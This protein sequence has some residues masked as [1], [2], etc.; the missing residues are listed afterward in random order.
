MLHEDK[1]QK[2]PFLIDMLLQLESNKIR[3][4]F[5][6]ASSTTSKTE[7]DDY[8]ILLEADMGEA[9]EDVLMSSISLDDSSHLLNLDDVDDEAS[10]TAAVLMCSARHPSYQSLTSVAPPEETLFDAKEQRYEWN[11]EFS[12]LKKLR[13]TRLSTVVEDDHAPMFQSTTKL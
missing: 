5:N 6:D 9:T 12:M 3:N 11:D 7:E 1:H 10:K 2:S 4:K 8:D 13:R